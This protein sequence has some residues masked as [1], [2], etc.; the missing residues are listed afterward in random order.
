MYEF[1]KEYVMDDDEV[2]IVKKKCHWLFKKKEFKKSKC[3]FAM[4]SED[5]L[6]FFF[7]GGPTSMQTDMRKLSR[8]NVSCTFPPPFKLI[9]GCYQIPEAKKS[10]PS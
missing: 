8:L 6:F 1:A 10:H 4:Y 9:S 2:S 7:P 5:C 3:H